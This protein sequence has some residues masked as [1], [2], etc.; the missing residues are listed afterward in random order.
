MG[1]WQWVE[2]RPLIRE[3]LEGDQLDLISGQSQV[4]GEAKG[5]LQSAERQQLPLL[6][7]YHGP[8]TM[9]SAFCVINSPCHCHDDTDLGAFMTPLHRCGSRGA[10]RL[11]ACL[12]LHS[13]DTTKLTFEPREEQAKSRLGRGRSGGLRGRRETGQAAWAFPVRSGAGVHMQLLGS[14]GK[15]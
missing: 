10:E 3:R 1:M 6:S 12:R 14:G 7:R 5:H 8:G 9:L 11:R 15:A 13:L 4:R 2:I